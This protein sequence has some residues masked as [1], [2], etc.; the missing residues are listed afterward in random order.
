VI[1]GNNF[2][3]VLVIIKSFPMITITYD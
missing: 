2:S 3:T 1:I